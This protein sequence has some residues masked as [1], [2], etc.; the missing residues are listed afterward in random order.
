M[1]QRVLTISM[2]ALLL[3]ISASTAAAQKADFSGTWALDKNRSEGLPPG[4][5]QAMTAKQTGDRV[6]I[7]VKV[8]SSRGDQQVKDLYILDGKETDF[9]PPAAP[10]VQVSKGK[11]TSK[12]S[13]D[14]KG[15]DVSEEATIEGE[16][17]PA[18]IKVTRHWQ[19]SDDAKTLTI[20]DMTM[21]GPAGSR[22]TKRVF[23][24]K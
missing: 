24:R 16:E 15:F 8:T 4:A 21:D 14:G 12:W 13:A 17:G 6:E 7:D 2:A 5:D 18:T 22:K 20:D 9:D 23:V 19:L 1:M 3:V 11:R 10:G